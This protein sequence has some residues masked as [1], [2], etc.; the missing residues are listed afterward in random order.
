MYVCLV[1]VGFVVL[2]TDPNSSLV[3]LMQSTR[4]KGVELLTPFQ[5]DVKTLKIILQGGFFSV[6]SLVSCLISWS[7]SV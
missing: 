6:N 5:H 7:S 2:L 3:T 4:E 1:N